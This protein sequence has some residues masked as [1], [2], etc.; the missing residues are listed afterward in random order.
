MTGNDPKTTMQV[1]PSEAK[2]N[3]GERM[4]PTLIRTALR[5]VGLSA[6]KA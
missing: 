1:P 3:P 2:L 4:P 6:P 5:L